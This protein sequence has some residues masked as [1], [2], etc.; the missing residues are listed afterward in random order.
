MRTLV[1]LL[2]YT[3]VEA[4]LV[5]PAFS[6]LPA[7]APQS[8]P[9]TA[10]SSAMESSY[11]SMSVGDKLVQDL[12][13]MYVLHKAQDPVFY[14]VYEKLPAGGFGRLLRYRGQIG[15]SHWIDLEFVYQDELNRFTVLD[16]GSGRFYRVT[17]HKKQTESS[18]LF[19][20]KDEKG[21]TK[22]RCVPPA[23]SSKLILS[24]NVLPHWALPEIHSVLIDSIGLTEQEMWSERLV[25]GPPAGEPAQ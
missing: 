13:G 24:D 10:N 14:Q 8:L 19:P 17:F 18:C 12:G 16:Y 7:Q 5:P 15:N 21:F 11:I 23:F 2:I 9:V 22:D 4:C 1:T 6:S 20:P 3:V 25:R